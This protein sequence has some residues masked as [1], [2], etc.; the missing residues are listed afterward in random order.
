MSTFRTIQM[1]SYSMLLTVSMIHGKKSER[2]RFLNKDTTVYKSQYGQ[3]RYLNEIFFHDKRDGVFVDIGANDGLSH[4]NTWFYEKNLG[5]KGICIEPSPTTYQELVKKRSSICINGAITPEEGKVIFR[6]MKGDASKLSGIESEYDPRQIKKWR[7][8][9]R[10]HELVEVDGYR[11]NDILEKHTLYYIDFLSLDT[12]GGELEIL[13]SID[14]DRFYIHTMTVENNY[15]SKEF[16][17][18]L[19]SKGFNY[20]R[21][22][23]KDEV[24]VN[25]KPYERS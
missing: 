5:W 14:F 4:S 16:R 11:L 2:G 3:D 18:F 1:I 17:E 10:E 13:N 20:L 25:T 9:K 21:N 7:L 23:W 8:N 22:Y 6:D 19:E 24:Y 15:D 12:E